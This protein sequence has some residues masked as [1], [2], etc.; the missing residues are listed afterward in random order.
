MSEPAK[1][2]GV[3]EKT[4]PE[5]TSG[6]RNLHENVFAKFQKWSKIRKNLNK[7]CTINFTLNKLSKNPQK[8]LRY[9]DS[10]T[11]SVFMVPQ[12][13]FRNIR[14]EIRIF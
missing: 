11:Y 9:T 12:Q 13:Y 6:G 7:L 4:S 10:I 5:V 2:I 3:I 8:I 14:H 1:R